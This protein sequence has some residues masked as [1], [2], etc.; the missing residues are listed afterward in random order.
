M[1]IKSLFAA[2]LTGILCLSACV[3]NVESPEVTALRSARADEIKALAELHRA[4]A[5][6]ATTTANAQAELAKA[7][8]EL[9]KAQAELA[10]AQA[11][12]QKAQAAYYNARTDTEKANAAQALAQAQVAQA[13]AEQQIANIL[14]QM[15]QDVLYNQAALLSAQQA[16]ENAVANQN[17]NDANFISQLMNDY[18]NFSNQLYY[19]QQ[20]LLTDQN[21][22]A[23]LKAHTIDPNTALAAQIADLEKEIANAKTEIEAIKKYVGEDVETL[24]AKKE[25]LRLKVNEL[26]KDYQ[27]KSTARNEASNDLY[28][29]ANH[30]YNDVV[31]VGLVN[32]VLYLSDYN[33]SSF[34][35]N[36]ISYTAVEV[37][38]VT[39]GGSLKSR[40]NEEM[41][42][43]GYGVSEYYFEGA[44]AT[45]E[46]DPTVFILYND[47]QLRYYDWNNAIHYPEAVD[48]VYPEGHSTMAD[49]GWFAR[50]L[51]ADN[52]KAIY[53]AAKAAI[54]KAIAAAKEAEDTAAE[55]AQKANLETLEEAW[56]KAEA[57]LK[58]LAAAKPGYLAEIEKFDKLFDAYVKAWKEAWDA[59]KA[60]QDA[61]T[62]YNVVN[63]QL[64]Q[65]YQTIDENGNYYW[66]T[67]EER[68]E[69]LE[70]LIEN[71]EQQ[72]QNIKDQIANNTTN[73]EQTIAMYE[74]NIKQLEQRIE[75][76]QKAVDTL[77]AQLDA[78]LE[79]MSTG[80][81]EGEGGE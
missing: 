44:P 40:N 7:Q 9:T 25:E 6:A 66:M 69:T 50:D 36:Y 38:G 29:Q 52:V 15:E 68:I 47:D 79:A 81:G 31:Y 72:I 4:E 64:N 80:E 57:G 19:A 14:A 23:K 43:K 53:T 17:A 55:E 32:D 63:N 70:N 22:L 42:E 65:G 75:V 71:N 49:Q 11:E 76:L 39:Y 61:D 60:Y 13:Q 34:I 58:E 24:I 46:T 41:W 28:D 67:P 56:A 27:D 20:Q 48:G 5:A 78:A 45:G 51:N 77:K 59:N 21:E 62:E 54:E 30:I 3:K 26:R 74:N 2:A 16:L 12:Y 73:D 10:K 8:A 18:L 35:Y 37:E 33:V 1:Q